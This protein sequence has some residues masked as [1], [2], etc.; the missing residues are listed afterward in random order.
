MA[1]LIIEKENGERVVVRND[2]PEYVSKY[3]IF[4][5]GDYIARKLWTEEDVR[6]ELIVHGYEGTQDEIDAVVN[7]GELDLLN[8]CTDYDWWC[9]DYA[10]ETAQIHG[11]LP[12]VSEDEAI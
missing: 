5:G 2:L 7:T 6:T 4:Y 1:S 10:I 8:D 3:N 11:D 12:E 9:I